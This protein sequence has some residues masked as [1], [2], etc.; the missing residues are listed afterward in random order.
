[1]RMTDPHKIK[2]FLFA[3]RAVFTLASA[4]TGTRFTYKLCQKKEDPHVFWLHVLVAPDLYKFAGVVTDSHTAP[5]FTYR[6]SH[7]S[8]L[9]AT[10]PSIQ[11]VA[12]FL[13]HLFKSETLHPQLEFWHEGRCGKCGRALTVPE[14]I[15][16]GLGPECAA[17]MGVVRTKEGAA[18]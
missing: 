13:V 11:A 3:G 17:M 4:R 16:T 18:A 15:A 10:A 14:S 1:M 12:W 7:K 9:S 5:A 6:F 2:E 8:Q